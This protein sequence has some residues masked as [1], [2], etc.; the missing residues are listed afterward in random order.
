MVII[1]TP[2]NKGKQYKQNEKLKLWKQKNKGKIRAQMCHN[3]SE[4][5]RS[6]IDSSITVNT[7]FI[8]A[9]TTTAPAGNRTRVCTVAGYYS[10]TRPL[11]LLMIN[12]DDQLIYYFYLLKSSLINL[13]FAKFTVFLHLLFDIIKYVS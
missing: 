1:M 2:P 7:I 11:V 3:S 12:V 6:V 13:I 10:T 9:P 4:R 5:I 8:T